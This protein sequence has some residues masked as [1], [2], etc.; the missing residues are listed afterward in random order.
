[1][2]LDEIAEGLELADT[3]GCWSVITV[4]LALGADGPAFG[5]LITDEISLTDGPSR[6]A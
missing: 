6:R 5:G 1:M 4:D 3:G 2:K